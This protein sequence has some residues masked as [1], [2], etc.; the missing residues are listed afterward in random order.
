[1][2]TEEA[3][4]VDLKSIVYYED[5]FVE[6]SD[7]SVTLQDVCD[8]FGLAA[9]A[10]AFI[11]DRVSGQVVATLPF[12]KVP[13]PSA[14][15][16]AQ[17]GDLLLDLIISSGEREGKLEQQVSDADAEDETTVVAV[18]DA[19]NQ[20]VQLGAVELL[21]DE[22]VSRL[23]ADRLYRPEEA[24]TALRQMGYPPSVYS[25]FRVSRDPLARTGQDETLVANWRQTLG[26]PY[27]SAMDS[28][29][30]DLV[31]SLEGVMRL[32]PDLERMTA[33]ELL[34]VFEK[35]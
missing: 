16:A 12:E 13:L 30:V 25:P 18:D 23:A 14:Q 20:L 9:D 1:M 33:D 27:R 15:D 32:R 31:S 22:D 6:I 4:T 24:P 10:A 35:P 8:A 28:Y 5:R 34:A 3:H 11:Q 17:D 2:E 29:Q 26:G 19:V 21:V 7:P